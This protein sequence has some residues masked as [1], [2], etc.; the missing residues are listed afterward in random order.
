MRAMVQYMVGLVCLLVMFIVMLVLGFM[1]QSVIP[2]HFEELFK[3]RFVD[4]T[5]NRLFGVMTYEQVHTHV[6]S[7]ILMV[8]VG[9][10]V[11]VDGLVS[12]KSPFARHARLQHGAET[13]VLLQILAIM[14]EL[15][16][17]KHNKEELL[18]GD[19][20]SGDEPMEEQTQALRK[21]AAQEAAMINDMR[22]QARIRSLVN[23]TANPLAGDGV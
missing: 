11:T 7:N 17:G 13:T 21:V 16:L 8:V 20:H 23:S 2:T 3:R 18:L 6:E 15:W 12:L 22:E 1:Y 14:G 4:D 19:F 10:S 9:C 5:W